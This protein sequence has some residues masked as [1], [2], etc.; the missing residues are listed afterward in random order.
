MGGAFLKALKWSI[1]VVLMIGGLWG[2]YHASIV[3]DFRFIMVSVLCFGAVYLVYRKWSDMPLKVMLGSMALIGLL[4]A[5]AQ[6]QYA[7]LL[8]FIGTGYELPFEGFF[9]VWAALVAT[10][11]TVLMTF[12][13]WKFDG[14]DY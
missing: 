8:L 6:P 13:F 4:G 11:G 3:S 12:V 1:I 7:P 14:D 2:L 5:M 10:V 9:K